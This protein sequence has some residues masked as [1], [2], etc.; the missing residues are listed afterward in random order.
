MDLDDFL[1][2]ITPAVDDDDYVAKV[3]S[4]SWR[5]EITDILDAEMLSPTKAMEWLASR[6]RDTPLSISRMVLNEHE[7]LKRVRPRG[8]PTGPRP[9]GPTPRK[10]ADDIACYLAVEW[11]KMRGVKPTPACVRVGKLMN[12]SPQTVIDACNREKLR[13]EKSPE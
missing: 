13:L 7:E 3:T 10:M 6:G 5:A 8:R 2:E 1:A 12:L 4:E 11:L 9:T